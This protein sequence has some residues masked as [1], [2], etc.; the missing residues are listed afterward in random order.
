MCDADGRHLR[1]HTLDSIQVC[2]FLLSSAASEDPS[3]ALL[4]ARGALLDARKQMDL[5]DTGFSVEF[6]IPLE[7]ALES[8]DYDGQ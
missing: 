2:G 8:S 1:E 3:K 4:Q 7:E 6:L 5:R